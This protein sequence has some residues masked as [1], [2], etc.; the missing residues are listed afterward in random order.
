M[1]ERHVANGT[2]G[3]ILQ[4]LFALLF[5]AALTGQASAAN[6]TATYTNTSSGGS[7]NYTL[8]SGQSLKIASG[9]YTG[10]VEFGSGSTICVE[11]GATFAGSLNNPAGTLANYGTATLAGA[12]FN[13]GTV[14]DNYGTFTFTGNPNTNGLTTF[15]NHTNATMSAPTFQLGS[16]S[17]FTNDGL[18]TATGDLNTTLGTTLTNNYRIEVNGN[19]NPDGTFT[20]NGRAYAKKFINMNSDATIINNCTFV[21]YDG[22][23]S[24][25]PNVT[26]NGVIS[27]SP[28]SLSSTDK[29]VDFTS[30]TTGVKGTDAR[31]VSGALALL[32]A[33]DINSSATLTS[34][35]PGNDIT[36]LLSSV[37]THQ[38]NPQAYTN[39][40][41]R[42]YLNTDLN[43]D[44]KTLFTGPNNDANALMGNVIMHPQNSNF[45]ANYIVHGGLQ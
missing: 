14:I 16:N 29:L 3:F 17:T 9:T 32:W 35:G 27:A 26:N 33:G 10:T 45:A 4:I 36:N 31:F 12:A 24:N 18:F 5:L 6:C 44:G 20:N 13:A 11:T 30:S 7:T 21:S 42:G 19:F 38:D 41:L 39:F 40:T 25:N 2:V 28:L 1:P 37:I 22:F 43:M 23:N 34:S 8:A 15:N